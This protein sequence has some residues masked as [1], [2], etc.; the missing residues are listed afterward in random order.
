MSSKAERKAIKKAQ[1]EILK[2]YDELWTNP[3]KKPYLE[4]VVLNIGVGSGGEELERAAS[5]LKTITGK[6]P[7]KTLSKKNIKEFNLR[8]GRAIGI[9]VTIRGVEAEKLLKRLF[10]V[11]ND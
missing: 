6:E 1:K 9:K 2:E 11:N 5:V 8:K 7:V 10:L 4:K 3:M